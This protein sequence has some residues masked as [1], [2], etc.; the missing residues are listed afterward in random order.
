MWFLSGLEFGNGER[1]SQLTRVETKCTKPQAP[2]WC[3]V[4]EFST[5]TVTSTQT[6]KNVRR[7]KPAPNCLQHNVRR[8]ALSAKFPKH[9]NKNTY[10]NRRRI[11]GSASSPALRPIRTKLLARLSSVF[12]ASTNSARFS[13]LSP[14]PASSEGI[15]FPILTKELALLF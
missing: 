4:T 10:K 9:K 1:R 3:H 5:E 7:Q 15:A 2:C 12:D 13:R 8:T 11:Q 14:A 6:L